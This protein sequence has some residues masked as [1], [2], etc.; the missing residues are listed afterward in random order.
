MHSS[1]RR[2]ALPQTTTSWYCRTVHCF[3]NIWFHKRT[4]PDEYRNGYWLATN[5]LSSRPLR[6]SSVFEQQKAR[7]G[8][9]HAILLT[10][11]RFPRENLRICAIIAKAIS[12]RSRT[13]GTVKCQ[14]RGTSVD[15]RNLEIAEEPQW[16]QTV[17]AC[18]EQQFYPKLENLATPLGIILG[19]LLKKN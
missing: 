18:Y 13:Y 9:P 12:F 5:H 14:G 16:N 3:Q 6:S 15:E 17:M 2:T 11:P 10:V 7:A 8:S 1:F 19:K 4:H